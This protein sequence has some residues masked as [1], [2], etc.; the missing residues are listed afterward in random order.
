MCQTL[1]KSGRCVFLD[2][3]PE[4]DVM[5]DIGEGGDHLLEFEDCG[6][7]ANGRANPGAVLH[8]LT[9]QLFDHCVLS[10]RL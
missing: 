7:T 2:D 3:G 9:N 10:P 6:G 8:H 4:F 1:N 5:E